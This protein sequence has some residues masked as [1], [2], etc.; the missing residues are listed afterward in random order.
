MCQGGDRSS[1]CGEETEGR[2]DRERGREWGGCMENRR[3]DQKD[4]G[5]NDEA[6]GWTDGFHPVCSHQRQRRPD[7][8]SVASRRWSLVLMPLDLHCHVTSPNLSAELPQGLMAD[9]HSSLLVTYQVVSV[10]WG[11]QTVLNWLQFMLPNVFTKC[12]C[13]PLLAL[14]PEK[15]KIV[16]LMTAETGSSSVAM[17]HHGIAYL[18]SRS[19]SEGMDSGNPH[20]RSTA[21]VTMTCSHVPP[22]THT[23]THPF[24]VTT[25]LSGEVFATV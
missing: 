6:S 22:I 19:M 12:A 21:T 11:L 25:W 10:S 23:H 4:C 9:S 7:R 24:C 8:R 16:F 18:I 5:H 3:D 20:H 1:G 15:R 13:S 2:T 17:T 14:N